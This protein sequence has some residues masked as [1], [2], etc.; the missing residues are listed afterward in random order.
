VE[1]KETQYAINRR[2]WR[3]WLRK[4]HDSKKEI[5]MVFY[6]K[7]TGK[8][9][10]S[11]DAAVEEALC[12][13]WID[14]IVKKMDE[15]KFVRKFTPRKSKSRWS[16]LNKKRARKM[17]DEGKMVETGLGRIRD[18]K[19][20]GEWFKSDLRGSRSEELKVPPY[21]KKALEVNAKA[22]K[23]FN[24]LAQSYRRH[25]IGWVSSAKREE[26]RKRRLQEAVQ[27]LEQNKKLGLK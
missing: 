4:N 15:E 10:I 27:L 9:G 14:S 17:I 6:K 19:E 13:G 18:A 11:Y 23:N 3:A 12:F 21:F 7:H 20:S 5:W 24:N 26:T 25:F 8:P 2:D 22:R 16:E 1:L